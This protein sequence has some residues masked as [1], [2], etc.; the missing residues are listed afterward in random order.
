MG[1]NSKSTTASW[2]VPKYLEIT[3]HTAK[4]HRDREILKRDFKIFLI[5]LKREG[6]LSTF[7]GWIEAVP[8]GKRTASSAYARKEDRS[9]V[10]NPLP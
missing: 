4:S 6:D 3:Q 8:G 1:L 10:N 5:K 9:K 2:N 7:M